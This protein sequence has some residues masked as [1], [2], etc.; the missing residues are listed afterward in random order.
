MISDVVFA[1][2][3]GSKLPVAI[4]VFVLLLYIFFLF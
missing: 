2:A 3:F 4:L 1:G